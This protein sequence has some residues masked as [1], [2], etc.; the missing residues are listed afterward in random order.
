MNFQRF[1]LAEWQQFRK[2]DIEFHDRLTVLTGANGSGKTTILNI[3]AK[4]HDWQVPSLATPKRFGPSKTM[5]FVT[6]L[7]G[8]IDKS[9]ENSIGRIYYSNSSVATLTI[10]KSDVAQYQIA[11]DGQ[12]QVPCFFIPSHRSVFRY[13]Q[14]S[15]LPVAPQGKDQAFQKVWNSTK[16]RYFGGGDE[17][18]SYHMK[19]TLIAWNIIGHGNDDMA[20]EP[21]KLELYEGFQS[22]LKKLLPSGL[23]F[24]RFAIRNMEIV[25]ECDTGEFLIDAASG[26]IS[27]LIELAWHVFMYST[28]DHGEFTVLIDEL[29]NHLHPT[30]QRR[31]LSNLLEAF[32]SARFIVSTHSPLIVNSVRNSRVYVLRY[33]QDHEIHSER[34]DFENQAR[35][36]SEILDQVLGVSFTMPT[37]A[38]EELN[39]IV[40]DYRKKE[41]SEASL[42]ELRQSLNVIGLG[43]LMPKVFSDILE[44]SSDPS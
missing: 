26:G 19:E 41:I 35:S 11:I 4:H 24:K 23:G 37:W 10:P 40:A 16:G 36:A 29:E 8:G 13:R 32:P 34:L 7:F 1:E 22:S 30:M 42:S 43:H 14:I 44:R 15:A 39:K 31:I 27:T 25:L 2:I 21:E 28:K 6:R 3:L 38:E 33:N 12:Q 20:P 17:A 9:A 18:S 5:K